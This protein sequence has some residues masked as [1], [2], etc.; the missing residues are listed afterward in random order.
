MLM[1]GAMIT[2]VSLFFTAFSP[3]SGWDIVDFTYWTS[4]GFILVLTIGELIWSPRLSQFTAAIAPKGQEG[5]YLGLAMVPY[6]AAKTVVGLFSGHMLERW[7]P[8]FPKGEPI[9][10][11]RIA[12]GEIS[13][14]DSPYVMF[15]ILGLVALVGT[16][17]VVL[18]RKWFT[19]SMKDPGKMAAGH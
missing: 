11:A 15:L 9:M 13:Y 10:G 2:S 16:T 7:C 8:E 5:T 19:A 12:A 14:W 6:F 4:L 1:V 18:K 3:A 17:I